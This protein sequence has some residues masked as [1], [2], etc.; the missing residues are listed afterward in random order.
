MTNPKG[1]KLE[2]AAV[3]WLRTHGWQFARRIVKEGQRDKGDVTLG[4]GIP[5]T[6]ECKNE[7]S[8]DIAGGQRELAE[9][10]RNAGN[11]WGFA[12]HK[13]RGTTNVGEYY[14]VLPV[15]M[16]MEILEQALEYE[17]SR[18]PRRRKRVIP[19]LEPD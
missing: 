14:A 8:M 4:D 13:K 3:N 1:T 18:L 2:T 16:L 19:R 15:A 7:K 11:K 5:V 10:M 9:E 17:G 12:L 6:I